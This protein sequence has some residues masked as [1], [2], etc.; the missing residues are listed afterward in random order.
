MILT[1]IIDVNENAYHLP[2]DDRVCALFAGTLAL[3]TRF[4]GGGS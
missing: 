4:A 3:M 1:L 2:M